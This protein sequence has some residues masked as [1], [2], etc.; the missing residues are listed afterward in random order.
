MNLPDLNDLYYFAQ[1]VD[2]GGFAPAGRALGMPKSK[3]SRRVALLEQRL[4][5]QLLMRST[6]SFTVTEAGKAYYQH[7]RAMMTEAAAAEEAIALVQATPR[8]TVRFSCPVA[9]LNARVSPM[10]ATFMH[11]YPEVSVYVEET[12]R[13]VDV[14]AEGFDFAIRVRP[15]PLQ[16]S[17]LILR[18]FSDRG[19]CLVASPALLAQ[20]PKLHGPADL[21]Q[22][23]SMDLG[24][25]REDHR[26]ILVG[27]DKAMADVRH[28][29]R[30]VTQSMLVLRDAAIAG[31]GIV[32]LP[33]MFFTEE[34]AKGALVNVLPAWEPRRE[35]IHAVY[36]SRRGQLP[37]VRL[38]LD[39]IAAQFA[40][41]TED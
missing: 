30:L 40:Q 34:A 20:Y 32:K 23:P 2:H 18:P 35:I 38:L 1:V 37:A 16:D 36:A 41:L 33:R 14:V 11:T 8:G 10:L 7:C 24:T 6:R 22:L 4:G 27:P 21:A 12:N 26:W 25:P 28:K 3:L 15:A 31:V 9:L 29:P 39:F 13:R 5:T 19:Q 17:D